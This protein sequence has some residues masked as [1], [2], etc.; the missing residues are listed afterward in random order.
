[1][2]YQEESIYGLYVIFEIKILSLFRADID[3]KL[4]YK[5][6]LDTLLVIW[7]KKTHNH[8]HM[9]ENNKIIILHKSV[10]HE[11][12]AASSFDLSFTHFSYGKLRH[13]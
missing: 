10:K 13:L 12:N 11:F 2:M 7:S 1:M 9:V 6:V 5:T 4:E 8:F 3:I